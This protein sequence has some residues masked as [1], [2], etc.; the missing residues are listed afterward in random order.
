MTAL[1]LYD[2]TR[3]DAAKNCMR[4]YYLRHCKNWRADSVAPALAFGG[5][6]SSSMDV[7]WSRH[8]DLYSSKAS[9]SEVIEVS[10]QAFITK[11]TSEGFPH[12]DDMS[13]DT[14]D[15]L[16]PRTPMIAQEMLYHY[17]DAR[18]H[19]LGST[20]FE[21]LTIEQPFIIPLDP[22]DPTLFYVGRMD[23]K[24]RL[25]NDI[26]GLD[27]KTSSLYSKSGV[28]QSTWLDS[29]AMNSQLDG[30]SYAGHYEHGDKFAGI[31]ID[32]A[33][34]HKSVH[35]GFKIVPIDKQLPQLDRWL[36]NTRTWVDQIEAN[37][38][39]LAEREVADTPY[40][41]AFP[42]NEKSCISYNSRCPYFDVCRMIGNPAKLKEPPIGFK[43]EKW[44][45]L[46]ELKLQSVLGPEAK[47]VA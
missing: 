27:H 35:D 12:P 15:D 17:A 46:N 2:S 39:V 22:E 47:D 24:F 33:L 31:W 16:T 25:R 19:I 9:R 13:P 45:P 28:F 11:W 20:D 29:W 43:V 37:K 32:G 5:A 10:Y 41:A 30:Y 14:I 18:E 1:K 21:L 26:Y 8:K 36:W 7:M 23:K 3:L 38:E 6:W 42:M 44:E 4:Y 40:L 34:V